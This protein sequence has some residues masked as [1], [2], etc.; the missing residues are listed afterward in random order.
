MAAE[1]A[2]GEKLKA[3]TRGRKIAWFLFKTGL[4][5]DKRW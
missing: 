3:L 5:E 4:P 2:G 1:I